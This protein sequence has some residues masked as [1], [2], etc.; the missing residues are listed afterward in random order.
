VMMIRAGYR[1]GRKLILH[2][3]GRGQGH[4]VQAGW[5]KTMERA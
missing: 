2:S 4:T 1:S 3:K 5:P